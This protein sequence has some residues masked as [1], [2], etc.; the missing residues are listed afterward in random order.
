MTRTIG[1]PDHVVIIRKISAAAISKPNG[2][3]TP[4]FMA[5]KEN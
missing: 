3:L 1:H 4:A 5:Q 2:H